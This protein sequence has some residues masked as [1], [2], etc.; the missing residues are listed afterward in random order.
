MI[1]ALDGK[2]GVAGGKGGSPSKGG[3][4]QAGAE[5]RISDAEIKE[6]TQAGFDPDKTAGLWIRMG[7]KGALTSATTI[8]RPSITC[9]D[10]FDEL[11]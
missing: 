2:S 11:N 9:S 3:K 10:A 8:G 7:L 5:Q 4:H 6:Y 1:K